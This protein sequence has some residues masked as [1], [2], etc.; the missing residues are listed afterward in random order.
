[1]RWGIFNAGPGYPRTVGLSHGI[2]KALVP[3]PKGLHITVEELLGEGQTVDGAWAQITCTKQGKPYRGDIVHIRTMLGNCGVAELEGMYYLEEDYAK[4]FDTYLTEWIKW[5]GYSKM[6][7]GV[8]RPRLVERA[9]EMGWAQFTEFVNRRS[10]NT[11]YL[12]EKNV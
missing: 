11:C 3:I 12:L 10:D 5:H 9:T 1:M 4:D 7:A 8:A 6:I 2:T